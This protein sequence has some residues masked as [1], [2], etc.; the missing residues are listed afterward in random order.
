L[1]YRIVF[2]V[3]GRA[4][5]LSHLETV[6][7]LLAALR[8]AGFDIALSRGP[9]PR[10]VIALAVPKGVGVES[11]ADMADVE[12]VGDHAPADVAER[13]ATRL[14]QGMT[15]VSVSEWHG[16]RAAS[17]VKSV[18]YVALVEPDV[19]W[20]RAVAEFAAA[21]EAIVLRVIPDK[22]NKTVDVKSS[23][24]SVACEPGRLT[25]ELVPTEAGSARPEE[26]VQAVAATVGATPT[27]TRL[28]RTEISLRDVAVGVSE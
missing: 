26:V 1:N 20:A 19:D 7:T 28:V 4:R 13:L 24:A 11:T 27:I 2:A 5:F 14:P 22:P 3:R 6:D 18:G 16:K 15:V 9:K 25:F 8:R 10:P 12:L 21:P 17:G 23:C